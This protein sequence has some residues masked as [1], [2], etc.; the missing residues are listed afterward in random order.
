MGNG[1]AGGRS[2]KARRKAGG[3]KDG[4]VESNKE[5]RAEFRKLGR[6]SGG[7]KEWRNWG[8]GKGVVAEGAEE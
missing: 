3:A 2:E 7:R 5:S 8:R 6:W 4:R 1:G